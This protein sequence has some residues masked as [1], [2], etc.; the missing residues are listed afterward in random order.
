MKWSIYQCIRM[1]EG[2]GI[3]WE[4][5]LRLFF[6]FFVRTISFRPRLRHVP[7]AHYGS[8]NSGTR[9][10]L[11]PRPLHVH[12]SYPL[13]F[14]Q[15]WNPFL[16]YFFSCRGWSVISLSFLEFSTSLLLFLFFSFI[17][18]PSFSSFL[19]IHFLLM[20]SVFPYPPFSFILFSFFFFFPL[21]F[22]F[23]HLFIYFL[24]AYISPFSCEYCSQPFPG[25]RFLV[26]P[27][28]KLYCEQDFME[29]H[30]KRCQVCN[31]IIRGKVHF[32]S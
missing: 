17:S 27:D 19:A 16:V 7:W 29:L 5:F 4:F 21:A 26:G 31:D 2:K 3:L 22:L 8:G 1:N 9:K 18:P 25:G 20:P 15:V 12:F 13:F 11:S 24:F 10:E 28:D 23:S 30:A 32:I 14:F 6:P